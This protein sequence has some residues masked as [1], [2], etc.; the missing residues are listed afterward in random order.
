MQQKKESCRKQ[1]TLF[2]NEHESFL[3]GRTQSH[4]RLQR[5]DCIL[6]RGHAHSFYFLRVD[7]IVFMGHTYSLSTSLT[8]EGMR[9]GSFD[10]GGELQVFMM[11]AGCICRTNCHLSSVSFTRWF[12]LCVCWWS[13]QL[14]A[15]W[16]TGKI[17]VLRLQMSVTVIVTILLSARVDCYVWHAPTQ[18]FDCFHPAMLTESVTGHSELHKSSSESA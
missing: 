13:N 8:A 12:C 15:H 18:C 16:T 2:G 5:A 4:S 7:G 14:I 1:I 9:R 6:F 10:V 17:K 3:G 11:R